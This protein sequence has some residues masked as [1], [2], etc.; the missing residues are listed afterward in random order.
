MMHRV[1]GERTMVSSRESA[2]ATKR[3]DL[4]VVIDAPLHGEGLPRQAFR[5]LGEQTLL[6]HAIA[7]ASRVVH[8]NQ[9]L[10]V[11]T[12]DDAV[13]LRAERAKCRVHV[14]HPID[15]GD[16]RFEAR[17]RPAL[18]RDGGTPGDHPV[19]LISLMTPLLTADDLSQG[20]EL[21]AAEGCEWVLGLSEKEGHR[22][23]PAGD[24]PPHLDADLLAP[25]RELMNSPRVRFVIARN[26][27][28]LTGDTLGEDRPAVVTIPHDRAL[29]I[30]S[31]QDLW[32]C[33]RLLSRRRIVFVVC[34]NQRVGMGHIYRVQQLA[35]EMNNHHTI[36]VCTAGSDLAA[37][38]LAENGYETVSQDGALADAV[39]AQRPDLIINDFLDTPPDYMRALKSAGKKVIN[40]E[41]L[42]PGAQLADL[43]VNEVYREDARLG[44]Q[45]AGPD[46]FCIRDEFLH[47]NPKPFSKKVA[48]VLITFGGV[49]E[50]N[51]TCRT[52]AVIADTAKTHGIRIN[53]VTGPGYSHSSI[54]RERIR[55]LGNP[56][57]TATS[58][59]KRMSEYMA[60]ADMAISSAGRTLFELASM[61]VP[62]IVMACNEREEN[63]PFASS[64][65]GF[66]Y[67]GRHDRVQDETLKAA[68]TRLVESYADRQAMSECLARFDFRHGKQRVL[69]A[70]ERV[71]GVPLK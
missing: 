15:S 20:M 10:L 59:T 38:V 53:I 48:Q 46:Y 5:M 40:F 56:D 42:G 17:L 57:V 35:H 16:A 24:E 65:G 7:L 9:Q 21:L 36:C 69:A 8:S 4:V 64:H 12:D 33:E 49:D 37:R 30:R 26:A 67:L 44:N 25:A 14:H 1:G 66:N 41:D 43:V 34:G 29:E 60:Q 6:S 45:C 71:F 22:W 51:L 28:L 23:H 47:V 39:L 58:G 68:F 32:I 54:L 55:A 61:R 63:H 3:G 19:M 13:A 18:V 31:Q 50:A 70:V 11:L 2:T 62:V 52:L 27:S